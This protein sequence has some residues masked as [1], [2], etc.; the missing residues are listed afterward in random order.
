MLCEPEVRQLQTCGVFLNSGAI[1]RIGPNR[2]WVE[3]ARRWAQQGVATLRLDMPG[4]GDSDGDEDVYRTREYVYDP[5][6]RDAAIAA[7]EEL[8]R[9]GVASEFLLAGLCSGAY[10]AFVVA[11]ADPRVRGVVLENPW[12]LHWDPDLERSRDLRKAFV[13]LRRRENIEWAI[14]FLRSALPRY[15]LALPLV[16]L[17]RWRRTRRNRATLDRLRERGVAVRIDLSLG[18]PLY[19]DLK[20]DRMVDD[21]ERWPN[22]TVEQVPAPDHTF[23]SLLLQRRLHRGLDEALARVRAH[24]Q[25]LAGAAAVSQ[26]A[27]SPPAASRAGASTAL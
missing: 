12:V 16:A 17:R 22:L 9:D 21:V 8:E 2:T 13:L 15:L 14:P 1:R 11:E 24:E 19:D 5:V 6:L 18:E 7:L 23:R 26:P 3:A 4:I 25:G 27:L 20:R 10:W